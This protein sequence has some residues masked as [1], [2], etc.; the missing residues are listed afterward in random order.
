MESQT[1]VEPGTEAGKQFFEEKEAER[2][3]RSFIH[4]SMHFLAAI[5][6]A[7]SGVLNFINGQVYAAV[8][9]LIAL[10]LVASV[11]IQ[12]RTIMRQER[13][14]DDLIIRIDDLQRELE[15]QDGGESQ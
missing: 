6:I 5:G 10:I 15:D 9:H 1:D 2:R 12:Y 7:V 8:A 4:K 14:E 3:S 11:H 13:I